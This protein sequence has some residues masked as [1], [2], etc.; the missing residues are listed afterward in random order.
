MLKRPSGFIH[1]VNT[2]QIRV[3]N[4]VW[5]ILEREVNPAVCRQDT[6]PVARRRSCQAV[7]VKLGN[8]ERQRPSTA[9]MPKRGV[10]LR[11]VEGAHVCVDDSK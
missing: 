10:S 3:L 1:R 6:Q 2:V 7:Q 4:C 5:G 11:S 8:Q 9:A